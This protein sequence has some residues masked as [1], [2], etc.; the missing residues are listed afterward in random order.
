MSGANAVE[1]A[2]P[3]GARNSRT[4]A[5][6]GISVTNPLWG[7]VAAQPPLKLH[8][9][10]GAVRLQSDLL[11]RSGASGVS[12]SAEPC[13]ASGVEAIDASGRPS[14]P[15]AQAVH[16]SVAVCCANSA[17]MAAPATPRRTRRDHRYPTRRWWRSSE[18][19]FVQRSE[20]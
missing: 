15:L 20:P 5:A 8:R 13:G 9:S 4:A 7:T 19:I 16:A 18:C 17:S 2:S 11:S 12:A 1:T 3:I 6:C 10:P 14:L